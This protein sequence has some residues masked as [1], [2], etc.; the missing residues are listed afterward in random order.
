MSNFAVTISCKLNEDDVTNTTIILDNVNED[1][2]NL[3]SQVTTHPVA[4][5]DI[6]ADHMYESPITM[7]ISGTFSMNGSKAFVINNEGTKLVDTQ[8]LFEKIKREGILCDIVKVQLVDSQEGSQLPRFKI[9]KNMVLNSIGW[10]EKVNSLGFTFG[11]MQVMLVNFS[12][13]EPD[14]RDENLPD[15]TEPDTLAFTDELIDW[16]EVNAII[17]KCLKECNLVLQDFLDI[18]QS[19]GASA[20]A[21]VLGG[22][23]LGAGVAIAL[24]T[25]MVSSSIAG[26]VG[27]VV[28]GVTAIA[29][30]GWGLYNLFSEIDK[31]NKYRIETFKPYNDQKKMDA[32]IKRYFEFKGGI[33]DQ[34]SVLNNAIKVYKISKN[35][36]QECLLNIDSNEYG[37]VF[38]RN[39]TDQ[40]YTL[41]VG[42][43]FNNGQIVKIISNIMGSPTNINE[44]N[45]QNVLFTTPNR[46]MKVY[47]LNGGDGLDLTNYF[48]V[49][50]TF[51]LEDYT[52]NLAKVIKEYGILK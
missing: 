29:L 25:L 31:R 16:E 37:F 18:I 9:R 43:Y 14:P 17:D 44:C 11:F 13:L 20:I 35:S 21:G 41:S 36:P 6:V 51:P 10:T 19:L 50:S 46:G 8:E 5:G 40:S 33:Y 26:P 7:S 24:K 49:T 45:E 27:W 48:I 34:L 22:V 42:D 23:A 12:V 3:M 2:I 1:S 47:L 52:E 39:N 28:A 15:I 4:N 32:E 30:I 38:T